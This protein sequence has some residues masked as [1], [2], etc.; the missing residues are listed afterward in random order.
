MA[1]GQPV[2]AASP[3]TAAP[4]GVPNSRARQ[5]ALVFSL[6]QDVSHLAQDAPRLPRWKGWTTMGDWLPFVNSLASFL[7]PAFLLHNFI[8]D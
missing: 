7:F 1:E 5:I 3:T 8:S 2:R 6:R 4:C